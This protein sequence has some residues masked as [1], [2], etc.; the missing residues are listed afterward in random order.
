ML[1]TNK[2]T[3]LN[4]AVFFVIVML[5]T[6]MISCT[7][8]MLQAVGQAMQETGKSYSY[9]TKLMLFGGQGHGT[10]LGCV[11]CSKYSTESILNSYGTYGSRYGETIFN[12]YSTYGSKYSSYSPCNPYASDPP[13]VVDGNGTYY[14]RLTINRYRPDRFGDADLLQ[15]LETVVCGD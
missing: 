1:A 5:S 14:G 6:T 7:A 15:W 9:S 11:S 4:N 2:H 8:E 12:R 3:I 13:V 10:Y